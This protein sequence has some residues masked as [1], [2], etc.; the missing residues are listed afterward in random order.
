MST[1]KLIGGYYNGPKAPD[2]LCFLLPVFK[3]ANGEFWLR[4]RSYGANYK[5]VEISIPK[6][7]ENLPEE[8][9]DQF[10]PLET[11]ISIEKPQEP[12]YMLRLRGKLYHGVTHKLLREVFKEIKTPQLIVEDLNF[13]ITE[14]MIRNK[15]DHF[16]SK[17]YLGKLTKE[18]Q[19][20]IIIAISNSDNLM[21]YHKDYFFS[22]LE[23]ND[24][25]SYGTFLSDFDKKDIDY[26]TRCIL[27]NQRKEELIQYIND[28]KNIPFKKEII[29]KEKIEAIKD[30]FENIEQEDP[31]LEEAAE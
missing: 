9:K 11:P 30:L 16:L 12:F 10:I 31:E 17:E 25:H 29:N 26:F 28:W 1:I 13:S 22:I 20:E 24:A 18:V 4:F 8:Y 27:E 21:S 14:F 3:G 23:K 6:L 19:L 2:T 7:E 5:V 15:D